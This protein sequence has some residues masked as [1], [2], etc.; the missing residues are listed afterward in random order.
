MN[1]ILYNTSGWIK[2]FKSE[3]F[4]SN[5]IFLG[6]NITKARAIWCLSSIYTSHL[7]KYQSFR[8]HFLI[9][10]EWFLF[11]LLIAYL[12]L[13]HLYLFKKLTKYGVPQ[14]ITWKIFE[15][16]KIKKFVSKRCFIKNKIRTHKVKLCS[17]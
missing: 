9:Q 5:N 11:L 7:N 10:L 15:D 13:F 16:F 2:V 1:D 3:N 4:I 14:S 12:R 17:C 6:A 8:F